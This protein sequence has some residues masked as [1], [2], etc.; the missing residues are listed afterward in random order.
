M[1]EAWSA[2]ESARIRRTGCCPRLYRQDWLSED[3]YTS[4]DAFAAF[5]GGRIDLAAGFPPFSGTGTVS[6]PDGTSMTEPENCADA[7][8]G[9]VYATADVL[10]LIGRTTGRPRTC[11]ERHS[12][13][14]ARFPFTRPLGDQVVLNLAGRPVV[15]PEPVPES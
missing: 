12:Y 9:E 2:S 14:Y 7:R 1:A 11:T 5:L 3:F 13:Q 6:F 10:V 8:P 15:F 4:G